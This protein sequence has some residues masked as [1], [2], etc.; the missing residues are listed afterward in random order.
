MSSWKLEIFSPIF[1]V[2]VASYVAVLITNIDNTTICSKLPRTSLTEDALESPQT[3]ETGYNLE[4]ST[5]LIK[6][7]H[8]YESSHLE[9]FCQIC[10]LKT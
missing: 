10:V 2:I 7:V 9:I 5:D 8:T 1:S 4:K 6:E 3:V